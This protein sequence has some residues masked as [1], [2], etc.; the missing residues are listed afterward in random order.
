M[1]NTKNA[2]IDKYL[3]DGCMRCHLGASPA[4]KINSWRKEI[5]L[6]REIALKSGLKE[7]LKWSIPCYTYKQKNVLM[8]AAFKEFCSL[9]FFKGA[10]LKDDK[11]LLEKAG[12]N[13]Q[14]ARLFR[15]RSKEEILAIQ[16]IISHYIQEAIEIEKKELKPVFV[17]KEQ[18][19]PS[20]LIEKMEEDKNFEKAFQ[21]LSPGRQRGYILHFSDA[22]QS[23]TRK[24]RIEAAYEKILKG[25]GIHDAYKKK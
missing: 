12:E 16:D 22:K 7:E 21:A 2:L 13:T 5:E 23:A 14:A 25:E 24:A 8:L 15:F 3:R 1:T 19:L 20:E 11:K 6:L 10:L 18:P 4:C 17:K 9:S